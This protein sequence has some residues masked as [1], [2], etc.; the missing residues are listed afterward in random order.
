MLGPYP[1]RAESSPR[2]IDDG[3][4]AAPDGYM[5]GMSGQR[6]NEGQDPVTAEYGRLADDYDS[7]WSFYVE[8]STRETVNRLQLA[9]GE[10]VLDVGCGTGALLDRLSTMH[11]VE[12][13]AGV[14][15]VPQMLDVA[16]QRLSSAMDLRVAW[17]EEL[18]FAAGE[19]D[20]V[21][22]CSMFHYIREPARALREM[23][24][25]LRPG[26]RL[27]ITDWCRDYLTCRCLDLFL[28][29]FNRA[30]FRTYSSHECARLLEQA[31]YSVTAVDRYRLNWLWGLMT[32]TAMKDTPGGT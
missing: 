24:R 6:S 16:R 32:L 19:F 27:V 5:A 28:R 17:A 3:R 9:P 7:R 29:W 25:V 31:G 14:D 15:P 21:V 30:H 4:A 11:P 22:S 23:Q 18:P 12:Q 2:D 10:R 1:E 13:L 20:L 26:G 8:A